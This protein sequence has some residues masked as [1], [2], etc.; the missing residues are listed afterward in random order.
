MKL[1]SEQSTLTFERRHPTKAE[2]EWAEGVKAKKIKPMST[3]PYS[4]YSTVLTYASPE[5]PPTIDVVVHTH[6]IGDLA[7]AAMPFEVFAEI[8][9]ELKQRSPIRPLMNIPIANGLRGYLPTPDQHRL[10]GYE[11]WIGVNQVQLDASIKMVDALVAMLRELTREAVSRPFL[12]LRRGR[13]N[14]ARHA[15]L[16]PWWLLRDCEHNRALAHDATTKTG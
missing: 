2:M 3:S 10:G 8:S 16:D 13:A 4:T 7:V 6:R 11:T 1:S 15:P 5:M 14:G 9:L 12:Q